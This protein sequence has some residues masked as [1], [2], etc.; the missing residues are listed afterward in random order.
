MRWGKARTN[1]R[2][3]Q[4]HVAGETDQIDLMGLEAGDD[5]GIMFGARAS[6][7]LDHFGC[8]SCAAGGLDSRR[9]AAVGDH[10]RDAGIGYATLSDCLSDG[11]KV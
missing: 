2:G 10:D 9:I 3:Q 6:P 8:K 5:L 11:E 1:S 7:G 4:P